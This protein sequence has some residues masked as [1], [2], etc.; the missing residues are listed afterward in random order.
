MAATRARNKRPTAR[1]KPTPRQAP[2]PP[3]ST[4]PHTPWPWPRS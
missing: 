1:K 3:A 4:T 2:Q